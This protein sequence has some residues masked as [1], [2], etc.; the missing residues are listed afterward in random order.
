VFFLFKKHGS[1][2]VFKVMESWSYGRLFIRMRAS[3]TPRLHHSITSNQNKNSSIARGIFVAWLEAWF[4]LAIALAAINFAVSTI[5]LDG[6]LKRELCDSNT[7][8]SAGQVQRRD[9]V[10]LART[11]VLEVVHNG[12]TSMN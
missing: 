12:M 3:F 11:S 4:A 9:I 1:R 8:I 2:G 5:F 7:A 10:H 6:R